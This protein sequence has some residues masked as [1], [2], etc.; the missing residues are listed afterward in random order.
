MY[1]F[2][3][4]YVYVCVYT[5][6]GMYTCAAQRNSFEPQ[7]RSFR[8]RPFANVGRKFTLLTCS[9]LSRYIAL[10][11]QSLFKDGHASYSPMMVIVSRIQIMPTLGTKVCK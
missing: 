6:K 3:N 10:R 9:F 5:Y 11:S 2:I 8:R 4:M 1:V 7:A